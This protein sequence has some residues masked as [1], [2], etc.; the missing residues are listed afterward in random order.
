MMRA[1]RKIALTTCAIVAVAVVGLPLLFAWAP[2]LSRIRLLG[3]RLPWLILSA[4]VPPVWV[5]VAGR[6]VRHAER[7]ERR[8]VRD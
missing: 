7:A 5:A 8:I 2:G 6:H 3:F 4:M 1:Q